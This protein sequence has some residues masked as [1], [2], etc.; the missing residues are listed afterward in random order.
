LR[1]ILKIFKNIDKTRGYERLRPYYI[2]QEEKQ[3]GRKDQERQAR[4]DRYTMPA[5]E[6]TPVTKKEAEV[7]D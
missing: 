2:K 1:I 4:G 3:R 5:T 6:Q 7:E